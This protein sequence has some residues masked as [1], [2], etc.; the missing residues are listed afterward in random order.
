MLRPEVRHVLGVAFPHT[1]AGTSL[2]AELERSFLRLAYSVG[3]LSR[4][5]ESAAGY[6]AV[7]RQE[8]RD[9]VQRLQ[10]RYDVGE[11]VHI[12][13]TSLLVS[14]MTRLDE[15][16]EA[17]SN[18]GDP[19]VLT[20]VARQIAI[21]TLRREIALQEPDALE[22]Q[23]QDSQPFGVPWD[24]YGRTQAPGGRTACDSES[25]HRPM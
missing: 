16:T 23:A 20:S 24:F 7:L 8:V 5:G 21:E 25:H 15:A 14:D 9:A 11:S 4:S 6:F 17:A 19:S 2:D 12:V 22:S 10:S 3:R 13:F 18:D 1:D